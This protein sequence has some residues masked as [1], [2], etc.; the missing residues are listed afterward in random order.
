VLIDRRQ[1]RWAVVTAL[2][3]IIAVGFYLWVD[4]RSPQGLT[5]GTP[6]G[7]WYGILGSALMIYA[8][9]LSAHR[10]FPAAW[11]MGP[12]KVWLRGHLW[13][14]SLSVVL[15]VCHAHARLGT[16]VALSLWIVLAGI[17]L[18]GF[19]GL[20]LQ[21]ILP[22]WLARRF[23]DEAPYGQIPYLCRLYREQADTLVDDVAPAEAAAMVPPSTSMP[24]YRGPT[25][26]AEL[27][28]FHETEIRP[29]LSAP[30]PRRSRLLSELWTETHLSALRRRLGL[31]GGGGA[32]DKA[33]EAL[34][35]LEELLR[36]R[37][38]LAE[39]ERM[40]RWLH[41]W[42][43]LHVPLSAALLVLGIVHVVMSLYF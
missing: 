28:T 25:F 39:Q 12:R 41:D 27:R 38:R 13:L 6:I 20:I 30:V 8:G 14:G 19:Y 31:R 26:A 33:A 15:I 21:Q 11:W 5:G 32:A 22:G 10:L 2:I 23:P 42:L 7:L 43:L 34:D 18:T 16:G 1:T 29:F 37:R 4:S 3:G 24:A 9:L 17:V 35:Q 40:W 36:D